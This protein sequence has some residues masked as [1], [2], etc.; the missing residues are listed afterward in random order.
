MKVV[1]TPILAKRV[2]KKFSWY[3]N[4][5]SKNIYLTFDDGPT[6]EITDWVLET[7]DQFNAKATFFCTGRKVEK[8]PE[9]YQKILDK[10]HKTGNHTY[11]HLNGWKTKKEEYIHD[12]ELA[13]E[14]IDSVLFRPPYGKIKPSQQKLLLKN[15]K[16][17]LW[18]ILSWDF[19]LKTNKEQCLNNVIEKTEG[20]NIVLFH[21]SEKA[22]ES[23][24]YALPKFLDRFTNKGYCFD[25]IK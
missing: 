9:I 14:L 10:G 18:D 20:G 8:H 11:S 25:S 23:L 19:D 17:V 16:I 4:P 24:Y 2:F 13:K 7:L 12:V 21:D 15:Y 6:P 5:E 1:K 22:K 3:F